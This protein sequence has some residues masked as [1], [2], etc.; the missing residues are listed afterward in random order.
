MSPHPFLTKEVRCYDLL[1]LPMTTHSHGYSCHV[2]SVT[3][4]F[5]CI[6][7]LNKIANEISP[8][9]FYRLF[10]THLLATA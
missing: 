3:V 8:H 1:D 2:Q 10:R 4:L 7:T 6:I 5:V 9:L